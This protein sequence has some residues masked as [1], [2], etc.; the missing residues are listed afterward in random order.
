MVPQIPLVLPLLGRS[1]WQ[2]RLDGGFMS[3]IS[4][5]Q[6]TD[7]HFP[8][9]PEDR[10]YGADPAGNLRRVV[11]RVREMA[12]R[13]RC[14]VISGDLTED[15]LPASYR[16]VETAL[17]ELRAVFGVPIL[18]GLGN[19]DRRG[20]FRQVIRGERTAADEGARYYYSARIGAL[21]ILMLDSLVPSELYGELGPA[22]LAWLA[23][24]LRD[25]VLPRGLPRATDNILVDADALRA[26]LR[27]RPI[28]GV[29]AGHSHVVSAAPFAGAL[30]ITAPAVGSLFDPG[31]VDGIRMLGG[32]LFVLKTGCGWNMLPR[33]LGCG[34]GSTCWRRL[35]DWQAAGVWH[36]LHR[37][38]LDRLGALGAL[39]WSRVSVDSAS[40]RAEKG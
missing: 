9:R 2:F 16:H 25:P 18:L 21:R 17:A 31:T 33:A 34:S 22:Q 12:V 11:A 32:I 29:L 3:A 13:P 37:A 20:P 19:H 15:A 30:A 23:E 35:R 6:L 27:D 7:L 40:L 10:P 28:L 14:I 4:F 5:I 39:D 8:P 38:I 24:Q 36:A 26:V 1:D